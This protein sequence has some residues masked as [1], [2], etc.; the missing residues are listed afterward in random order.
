MRPGSLGVV[1]LV[2]ESGAIDV[3]D[4][5]EGKVEL[6]VNRTYAVRIAVQ[7][8]VGVAVKIIKTGKAVLPS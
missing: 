8:Q 6:A 5:V 3:V 4:F 2:L 1:S 7:V